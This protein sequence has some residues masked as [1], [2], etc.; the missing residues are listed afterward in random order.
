M[1]I[2]DII[3][4]KEADKELTYEEIK[5]MVEGYVSGEVADYQ[6][7]SLLMAIC[8]RGMSVEETSYLTELMYLSGDHI[9][10]R[11]IEG[12]KVDKHSTG[13]IGDK[14]TLVLAPLVASLGVPV[15]KMSGR[16]L[17]LTGGTIDKLESIEGFQTSVSIASFIQEVKDIGVALV[18][19]T[20]NLVPADK[21]IYSLRDTTGT[22]ESIPLVAASIMSKKLASGA[23]KFV[24]DVKVGKGAIMQTL[25]EARKLASLMISIG[26]AHQKEVVCFLTNMEEPLGYAV[27]NGLEVLEAVQT[28]QGKG[29]KDLEELV[30]TLG[31]DMVRLGKDISREQ[32][33]HLVVKALASNKAYDK[34][35]E[36]V[37]YQGG[38][39]D[40]IACSS[41]QREVLSDKEGYIHS[42]DA[43]LVG[44]FVHE[45]G[46]GR[47]HKEDLI[48]YGVGVILHKKVGDFVHEK[49]LL[50]TVYYT[51]EVDF[52]CMQRAYTI[53]PGK[54]EI[55]PLIYDVIS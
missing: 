33:H 24:I 10:L 55:P 3:N 11:M 34:W 31:S 53:A 36:L 14:T 6:M 18:G 7:S 4:K 12:I 39:V 52:E 54:V 13:G 35:K 22:V 8:I 48:D 1:N 38:N 28:L 41:L 20:G 5:Y 16:G 42:L 23:N 30:I 2:I 37:Q 15:A 50:Y 44:T 25:P 19:Q 21:K 26:K 27:G 47:M 29:P 43:N 45:L 40:K 9:D 49:E 51:H 46:A 32:A 17:G